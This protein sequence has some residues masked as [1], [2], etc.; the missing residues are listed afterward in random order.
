MSL[1]PK[2]IESRRVDIILSGWPRI[3][4][5]AHSKTP[6][7]AG[8]GASRFSGPSFHVLYAAEDFST[9]FA[10]AV[11]RD[12]FEGKQR[13]Y[14]YRPYLETLMATTISSQPL[15]LID[16]TGGGAYELGIDTDASR[17]RG[18]G[19]G[20]LFA[21][22]IYT[23]TDLDGIL[24]DS[25]LTSRRCVAIFDRALPRVTGSDPIELVRVAALA[26]ELARLGIS[27]RRRRGL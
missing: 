9:A 27:L 22:F 7:G 26:A 2:K 12:R 17:A 14:L 11:V 19:G 16:L 5:A 15:Q 1:S 3:I 13:R 6:A 20:R 21:L 18:H 25:R 10:E 24:F 8:F 4:P 23:A